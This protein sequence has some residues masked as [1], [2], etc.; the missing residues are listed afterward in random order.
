M[1]TPLAIR[2]L[3]PMLLAVALS[4]AFAGSARADEDP[5]TV[6]RDAFLRGAKLV[7]DAQWAEALQAFEE[8]S[9][10]RSHA[11]TSFNIGACHRAMGKYTLARKDFERSLAENEKSGQKELSPA[12]ADETKRAAEEVGKLLAHVDLELRPEEVS[13]AVDGRPLEAMSDEGG[14]PVLLAGTMPVGPGKPAPKGKFSVL[15]DPGAHV[16]TVSRRG[17]ADAVR[18]ETLAPGATSELR[19]ELD[20]LPATMR[21][22]SAPEGG[23]VLVDGADVGLAPLTISRPAGRYHVTV[24]HKGFLPFET[25]AALDP[26]QSVDVTAK[27]AEDKPTLTQKWWFWT[28]AG[29]VLAG[30]ATA[31][32]FLTRPAPERPAVDGGGLGWAVKAP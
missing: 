5:K 14:K 21:V 16:I 3:L 19:L 25:Q 27:L 31:T 12:L 1:T 13:I 26:G 10:A 23:Q 30:A 6:A 29:V 9:R 20:R 28:G 7:R 22:A 18:N 24:K 4:G 11:L 8:S 32:Y 2:T 15:V 17:F